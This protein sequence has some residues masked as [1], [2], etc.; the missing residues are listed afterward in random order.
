MEAFADDLKMVQDLFVKGSANPPVE[1]NWPPRAG[2]V[3]WVRGLMARL[4]EPVARFRSMGH[5]VVESE[6]GEEAMRAYE[7]ILR[8]MTEFERR[9]V[10]EWSQELEHTSQ[11][12]LKQNLLR[13]EAGDE[14]HLRVNFDPALV[15]LLREV[16]YFKLLN[17]WKSSSQDLI[18]IPESAIEIYAKAEVFRQQTGNLELIVNIYNNMLA[19][20]VEVERPLV[21]SKLDSIDKVLLKGLKHMNWKSQAISDFIAQTMAIVRDANSVLQTCKANVKETQTLLQSFANNLMMD[22]KPI[23]TYTMEEYQEIFH[24]LLMTRYA[25]IEKGSLEMQ[26]HLDSSLK[27]L[28]VNKS[29]PAW[30]TYVDYFN[31]IVIDGIVNAIC[32]SMKY[33]KN[34]VISSI[35]THGTHAFV[36]GWFHSCSHRVDPAFPSL[37]PI[38]SNPK[39]G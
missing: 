38:S 7:A 4:D 1:S 8:S 13:R 10:Q 23:K 29:S 12:K 3:V 26:S 16:K 19:T 11:D 22:R 5:G 24:T 34:Q 2:A 14:G 25:A 37:S 18:Q 17:D 33:L 30:R 31:Q 39:S 6:E 15:C 9:Q 35:F 32:A 21:Q 20:L 27:V 36:W 28:K